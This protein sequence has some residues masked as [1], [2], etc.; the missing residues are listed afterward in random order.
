MKSIAV[1]LN[2]MSLGCIIWL[3]I[4]NGPPKSDEMFIIIAFAGANITSLIAI[5]RNQLFSDTSF[6]GLWLKRKK[7]EEQQKIDNLS[8]K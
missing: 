8:K 5:L 2:I 6:I 1:I 3:F 7:L 4:D